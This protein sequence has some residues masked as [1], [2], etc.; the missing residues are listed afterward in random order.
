MAEL[1]VSEKRRC[2][3]CRTVK[4]RADFFDRGDDR[5]GKRPECKDCSYASLVRYRAENGQDYDP[6]KARRW[7]QSSYRIRRKTFRGWIG[8][9]LTTRRQQCR[10]SDIEFTLTVDDIAAL[11]ELQNGKCALT[12]RELKWGADTNRG[13]NTLSMD[14][15]DAAGPYVPGNVRLVTHWANVARQRFTDDEFIESCRAVVR[16]AGKSV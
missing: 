1:S 11:Y 12:G 5:P 9:N 7:R 16:L 6:E 15:I 13:P 4:D 10:N 2:S 3:K 8:I 14:R